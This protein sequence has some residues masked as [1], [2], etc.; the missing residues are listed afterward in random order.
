M[1]N[2]ESIVDNSLQGD[3]GE[4]WL[5]VVAA[6]SGILHGR[7]TTLDLE[8]ADIELVWRGKL[9]KISYPTIKAQVKTTRRLPRLASGD[10]VYDLDVRTYEVLRQTDHS[11]PRVLVVFETA[12]TE[13]FRIT[14][15]GT[16]LLGIGAWSSLEGLP[17]TTNSA[18]VAVT[19]PASNTLDRSG[20]ERMLSTCGT[21]ASTIISEPNPW[22]ESS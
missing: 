20:L 4:T 16:L 2:F 1:R 10:F 17:A 12:D 15:D 19:L 18:T 7:P 3:F 5:E 14:A 6:G 22:G 13:R 11:V 21:G 8:K 9:G